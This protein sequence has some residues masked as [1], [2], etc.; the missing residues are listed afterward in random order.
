MLVVEAETIPLTRCNIV[1]A[2]PD[3][4]RVTKAC[5][6]KMYLPAGMKPSK[7]TFRIRGTSRDR[8]PGAIVGPPPGVFGGRQMRT[9]GTSQDRAEPARNRSPPCGRLPADTS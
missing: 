2:V 9:S 4:R 1:F 7:R 3:E 5:R 6:W 8:R